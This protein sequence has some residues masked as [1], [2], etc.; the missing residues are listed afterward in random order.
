MALSNYLEFMKA[1]P[2]FKSSDDH[3]HDLIISGRCLSTSNRSAPIRFASTRSTSMSSDVKSRPE[4][5][6]IFVPLIFVSTPPL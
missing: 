6:F 2:F 4:L 1:N 5:T 3:D